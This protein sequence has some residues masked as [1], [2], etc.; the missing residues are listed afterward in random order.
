MFDII[1]VGSSTID[2]FAKSKFSELIKIIDSKGE[3]DLLAYPT[4]AKILIEEL[5][6]T[7]GGGA[8][9]TAVCL[10]RLGNKV[11]CISK[12]GTGANSDKVIRHLKREGID[13]SLLVRSKKGRTGYRNSC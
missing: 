3:T 7:T 1:T 13:T 2:V 9:N 8:T 4:G 11:S 10:A 5:N 6:F 12:M